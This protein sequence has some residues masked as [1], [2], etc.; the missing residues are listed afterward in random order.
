MIHG[1]SSQMHDPGVPDCST[2]PT[3]RLRFVAAELLAILRQVS[4]RR[5]EDRRG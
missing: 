5:R 2:G 1:Q 3:G 4:Q